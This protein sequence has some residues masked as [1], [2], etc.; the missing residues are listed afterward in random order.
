MWLTEWNQ[1]YLPVQKLEQILL[2]ALAPHNVP[3]AS[4][5]ITL[6]QLFNLETMCTETIIFAESI[7]EF[8]HSST[9]Q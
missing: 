1:C 3:P 2:F 9:K 5:A 4:F 6:L 8:L 7:A